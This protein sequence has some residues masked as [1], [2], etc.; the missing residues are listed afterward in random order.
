MER[1]YRE[2]D[3]S[4]FTAPDRN[5]LTV[6]DIRVP[7]VVFENEDDVTTVGGTGLEERLADSLGHL[8]ALWEKRPAV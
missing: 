8:W 3:W 7:Y 6:R 5:Y 2:D 1:L 4:A